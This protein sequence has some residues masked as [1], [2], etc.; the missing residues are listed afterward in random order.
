MEMAT[1]QLIFRACLALVFAWAALAKWQSPGGLNA[2]L[3]AIGLEHKVVKLLSFLL[4]IAELSAAILLAIPFTAWYGGILAS[5]LLIAFIGYATRV[6]RSGKPVDCSCF[7]AKKQ[8]P[9]GWNTII[10]NSGLLL[11]SLII[12]FSGNSSFSEDQAI[13][14]SITTDKSMGGLIIGFILLQGLVIV[15][16]LNHKERAEKS[17]KTLEDVV[18]SGLPVGSKA[19]HFSLP[20]HRGK[21]THLGDLLAYKKE[22]IFLFISPVCP[23]CQVLLPIALSWHKELSKDFMLVFFS[24]KGESLQ[25]LEQTEGINFLVPA[26]GHIPLELYKTREVP[27]AVHVTASGRIGSRPAHGIQYIEKLAQDLASNS[28]KVL[29]YMKAS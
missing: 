13:I 12:T 11:M 22:M 15:K 29:T 16:L 8:V 23:A 6:I 2:S 5:L 1:S 4:P 26:N 18:F 3:Q 25:V 20:N 10:R 9:V 17:I 21:E 14:K 28:T 24:F 27:A 7:G 19:P